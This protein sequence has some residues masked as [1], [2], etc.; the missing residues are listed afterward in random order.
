ML[1]RFCDGFTH[2]SSEYHFR[3]LCWTS[4]WTMSEQLWDA[5]DYFNCTTM[6]QYERL[7][8]AHVW[9][10]PALKGRHLIF[11]SLEL[12]VQLYRIVKL[13]FKSMTWSSVFSPSRTLSSSL[14]CGSC[15]IICVLCMWLLHVARACG[16]CMWLVFVARAVYN[17]ACISLYYWSWL[18]DVIHY[19]LRS[20]FAWL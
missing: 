14:Y 5:S 1:V 6:P 19:N 15:S 13:L 18:I 17:A 4:L 16:S 8:V 20:M 3:R 9:C 2:G 12:S 10:G 11:N 7:L